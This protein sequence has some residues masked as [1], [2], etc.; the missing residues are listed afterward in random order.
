MFATMDNYVI[1]KKALAHGEITGQQ[2][3]IQHCVDVYSDVTTR[4]LKKGEH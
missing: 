4:V 1:R 2:T 3:E